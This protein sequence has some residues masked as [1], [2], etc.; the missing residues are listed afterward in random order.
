MP[1]PR[2][3][4]P[5]RESL[6]HRGWVR[7]RLKG[8][9]PEGPVE[10]CVPVAFSGNPVG[11]DRG[12]PSG[13]T[14]SSPHRDEPRSGGSPELRE[15]RRRPFFAFRVPTK[16]SANDT[17]GPGTSI[18]RQ[19]NRRSRAH[20]KSSLARHTLK[21]SCIRLAPAS[22]CGGDSRTPQSTAF[23][24]HQRTSIIAG[25]NSSQSYV[26]KARPR[27]SSEAL[28]KIS[29]QG[30]GERWEETTRHYGSTEQ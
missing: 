10:Q 23:D 17:S 22:M 6:V 21:R 3:L 16:G 2:P 12:L 13:T 4:S 7:M 8:Q 26:E 30:G 1:G 14:F 19:T 9:H 29:H 5:A 18:E 11:G 27:N 28:T 20:R 25:S 24:V 15:E